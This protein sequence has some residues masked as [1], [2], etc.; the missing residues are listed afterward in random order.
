[1]TFE[2]ALSFPSKYVLRQKQSSPPIRSPKPSC[3][4]TKRTS[5]NVWP[6]Q[7][8]ALP[9]RNDI[10]RKDEKRWPR[11]WKIWKHAE[12]SSTSWQS[13]PRLLYNP[14]AKPDAPSS[15]STSGVWS[16]LYWPGV[17][18]FFI[19]VIKPQRVK[20][21][22]VVHVFCWARGVSWTFKHKNVDELRGGRPHSWV[23]Y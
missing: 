13:R 12:V 14:T 8:R 23:P 5:C 4:V 7:P 9:Y 15:P 17:F 10:L 16:V 1:M 20:E 22:E 3:W 11:L 19:T 18:F 6:R 2:D 21:K